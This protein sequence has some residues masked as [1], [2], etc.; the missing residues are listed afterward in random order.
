MSFGA[1][2]TTKTAQNNLSGTSN[3][4]LNTLLPAETS[5][6]TTALNTGAGNVASGT[7]FFN[8][9]LQ[10]NNANTAAALQPS[11]NQIQ[12][13]VANNLNAIN[14]LMPRGGGRSSALFGQSFAPQSQIQSLFNSGRT[15]AASA[16]PQIGLQQQKL[17][18]GLFGLGNQS[19]NAATGANSALANSGMQQQYFSN[20]LDQQI[21]Q[22]LAGLLTTPYGGGTGGSGGILGQI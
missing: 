20:L 13:G 15:T 10:G 8:T 21:G 2:N 19:L 1:S 4:A 6:G 18:S 5:Q 11:I 22:G 17:G 14:T 12:G 16:L 3:A 9:L 7:N